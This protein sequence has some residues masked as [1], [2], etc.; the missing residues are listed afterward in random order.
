MK[1][2]L[3][4]LVCTLYFT[5]YT[6]QSAN[7]EITRP[8]P[9]AAGLSTYTTMPVSIQTGIP[10]ISYPL[11]SLGT[12]NK[13]VSINLGISYHA[14]NTL[15]D[16]WVSEVGRGWSFLGGG[17]VS[18]EIVGDF[19]ES[20]DDSSYSHYIKNEFND[21]YNFS[22]PEESGKFKIV[23]DIANNTF[24]VVKLTPYTSKVEYQRN[25]NQA[26]LIL[27]SFTITSE[28]GTQYI[29]RDYDINQMTVWKFERPF[30]AQYA[31]QKYRS[32]FYLSSVLDEN[33][34][35]LVKY[36]YL[37]D[38][39]YA[40]GSGNQITDTE[41]NK[42]SRIEVKGRGIIEINYDRNEEYAEY[43]DIFAITNIVLK[44]A[45]N[46]FVKKYT[47]D[48]SY[49]PASGSPALRRYLNSF[50]QVD[51]N[52]AVIE[53]Y[54]FTYENIFYTDQNNQPVNS[55]I[56]ELKRIQL[57]TRGMIEYNFG[58]PTMDTERTETLPIP[59]V[60]L[61][62]ISFTRAN[63]QRKYAFTLTDTKTLDIDAS[64]I[65]QV[66]AFPWAIQF[67]KKQGGSYVISHG[68]GEPIEPVPGFE[69]VQSRTFEPGEYYLD[70]Y[71]NDMSCPTTTLNDPALVHIWRE[72]DGPAVQ[73]IIK[74]RQMTGPA[75]I[76]NIKYYNASA[77]D[78][79]NP[80]APAKI[81]E[82]EYNKFDDAGV[83]SGF[84]VG[85]TRIYKN[86]KVSR[87]NNMGY[88]KYYFKAPDAYPQQG[89]FW[90][91]Y[92]LTRE[93]LLDKKE[94]YNASNQK[95]SE[96]V[97]D[98]T[99][100]EFDGP[101]YNLLSLQ[102]KT[103]WIKNN[104]VTSKSYFDSGTIEM[105]NEIF[106]NTHNN[107]PN[108]ERTT[109]FDGSIQETAYQ[110]AL[111]K[112]NQKLLS[113]NMVGQPLETTSVLKKNAADPGKVMARTE[114]MYENPGNKYPSSVRSY[115]S[116]NLLSSE[117]TFNRYDIRGNPEQYT[118]K[119]GIP[120]SMIWGYNK[121]Q[122]IAKVEGAAY[123]Q[124]LP[125]LGDII[126]KS[127][128]A[129]ISEQDLQNALDVFRNNANLKNYQITTYVYDS[130]ARM[131]MT[132]PPAGIRVIYQYDTAGR[133]EKIEDE[134][135]K[136]LKKYQ[137]NTGH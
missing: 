129:V 102:V 86:V 92:N 74:E 120:V 71:C 57:P 28:T 81:E 53:K 44:T 125:Y 131:K 70:L 46:V 80:P 127:D 88:T 42:L 123:D 8:T 58:F 133:L 41:S 34:Q 98:Y 106:R 79:V 115:D 99:I 77:I 37:R 85:D 116:Q 62:D 33:G 110:Y 124:V 111:E 84:P 128:A 16:E 97:Y 40:P 91:H 61:T 66:A 68:L 50:S 135:G 63:G 2:T 54:A 14:G 59:K 45:N 76:K 56:S 117:V 22:T 20:F 107:K 67:W 108:L 1:K 96:D 75:R 12:G 6:G 3:L 103:S 30:G 4:L 29:F 87:G 60:L 49:K 35:E 31:D 118:T 95:I 17:V 94:V 122:P 130:L 72:G 83:S 52:G 48:Y 69:Y 121:T 136:L 27:N 5:L 101:L 11:F 13:P 100:E 109:S 26:T 47:F 7:I 32:A 18:R 15:N 24:S 36:T 38:L 82:Y 114:T 65:G 21:I 43:N 51:Q 23:R 25:A 93:G 113:S 90:P 9:S 119:D 89:D 64:G 105:K 134:T 39:K 55:G 126:A 19:D 73:V 132:T 104:K 137:Y 78:A 10:D 112:N